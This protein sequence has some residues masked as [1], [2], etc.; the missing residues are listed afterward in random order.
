MY[1]LVLIFAF[2]IHA[3]K[4]LPESLVEDAKAHHEASH[5][6][7]PH[8]LI[9]DS[10]RS[11]WSARG[12]AF[13][14][15][16]GT[17]G[18]S[19]LRLY[20]A[21]DTGKVFVIAGDRFGLGKLK[22]TISGQVEEEDQ[23]LN[24]TYL[25]ELQ[26]ELFGQ[27]EEKESQFLKLEGRLTHVTGGVDAPGKTESSWLTLGPP[28]WRTH[29]WGPCISWIRYETGY[30]H[31]ELQQA[32]QI[33]NENA[34]LHFPVAEYFHAFEKM[35][36]EEKKQQARSLLTKFSEAN[37]E[38]TVSL[39]DKASSFLESL[40]ENPE[41]PLPEGSGKTG[42]EFAQKHVHDYTEYKSFHLISL[43]DWMA[44]MLEQLDGTV[45]ETVDIGEHELQKKDPLKN[46]T[47]FK[48]ASDRR[49][50]ELMKT[51]QDYFM[52]LHQEV[53]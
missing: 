40:R 43:K 9:E 52:K 48:Y 37:Q 49:F 8:T 25:R 22:I 51:H 42:F 26:E 33:M 17:F 12:N 4:D 21:R 28:I 18:V 38:T 3:G 19:I 36:P 27:L 24:Q 44:F 50:H 6:Q 10:L 14:L 30:E 39:S 29:G 1:V 45:E 32:V 7:D 16:S 31:E 23:T 35:G 5:R 2:F 11:V 34:N 46:M 41:L 53:S 13:D 47:L 20:K 15:V